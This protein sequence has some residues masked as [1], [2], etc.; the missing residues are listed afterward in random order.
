MIEKYYF[1]KVIKFTKLPCFC[2][3]MT[4]IK[5]AKD[6]L[7]SE[8][9]FI[10]KALSETQIKTQSKLIEER[11]LNAEW[12]HKSQRISCYVSTQSEVITTNIIKEAL[13]LKKDV[14][15]PRLV[16]SGKPHIGIHVILF[17][18]RFE[19]GNLQMEM[20]KLQNLQEFQTLGPSVWGIKQHSKSS[21]PEH[22]QMTGT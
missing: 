15:I 7:R 21:N 11:I 1:L 8:I 19:K 17:A 22:Y 3:R 12:F 18:F 14:F 2:F 20:T 6:L 9:K 5:L 4:N 13:K 16:D 10:V